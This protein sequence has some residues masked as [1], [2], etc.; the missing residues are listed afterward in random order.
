MLTLRVQHTHAV[1]MPLTLR[2]RSPCATATHA[3]VLQDGVLNNVPEIELRQAIVAEIRRF[4]PDAIFV[5]SPYYDFKQYKARAH[6]PTCCAT[7][8]AASP[9]LY[10]RLPS[11]AVHVAA[12]T[13]RGLE[14]PDHRTT[15]MRTLD[16]A[17]PSARDY[18]AFPS[19]LKSGLEP[20]ITSEIFLYA[21]D[22]IEVYVDIDSVLDVKVG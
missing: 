15:G 19:M 8:G 11:S 21:F 6:R 18:L 5:W 9:P 1:A 3:A 2:T 22:N 10:S 7:L 16:A 4:K 13:Q 20:W 14:H 17:Y 12:R